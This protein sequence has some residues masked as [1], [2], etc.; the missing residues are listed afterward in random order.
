MAPFSP[1]PLDVLEDDEPLP[2]VDL[3]RLSG[4][5]EPREALRQHRLVLPP[6]REVHLGLQLG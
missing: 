3:L 2:V 5:Q 1:P 6:H 4:A